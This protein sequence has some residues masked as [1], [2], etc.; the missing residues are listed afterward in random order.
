MAQDLVTRVIDYKAAFRLIPGAGILLSPGFGILDV[1]DDLLELTGR[2][3][4]DLLGRNLFDAF[5]ANPHAREDTGQCT[6]RAALAEAARSRGRVTIRLNQYDVE[7]PG[8]PGV[9]EERFWSGVATPALDEDGRVDMILLWGHDT[10]P[11]VSQVLA[12][13][14]AQD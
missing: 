12:Q 5:P 10:T 4:C 2:Q 6:L 7:D 13:A 9:F 11:I 1:S 8:M 3:R 14:A